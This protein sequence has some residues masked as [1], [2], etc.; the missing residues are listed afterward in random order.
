[1]GNEPVLPPRLQESVAGFVHALVSAGFAMFIL[2]TPD[3][4]MLDDPIYG[5]S[6]RC[7]LLLGVS[8][9]YFLW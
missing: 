1:M 7:V 9:G 4:A 3:Q 2:L 5:Y 8:S 6:E